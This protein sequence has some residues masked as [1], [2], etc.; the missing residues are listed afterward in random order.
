MELA[1]D[2]FDQ[3]EAYRHSTAALQKADLRSDFAFLPIFNLYSHAIALYLKAYLH[4]NGHSLDE[5]ESKYRNDFRRMKK[6]AEAYGLRFAG[7]DK[8]AIEYYIRTPL[9]VRLKYSATPYYSP[10]TVDELDGLCD[11]LRENVSALIG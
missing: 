5:L 9:A 11:T 1:Y 10:P 3:A 7:S 8:A 4:A 6:R 2:M